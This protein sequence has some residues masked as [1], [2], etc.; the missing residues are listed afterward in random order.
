MSEDFDTIVI[1]AGAVG[2]SIARALSK[3]KKKVLLIEKNTIVGSGISSRNSEVIHA[4]IY[5]QKNS[6]KSK[7][8]VNG[9]KLLI[10]FCSE[11][12]IPFQLVGKL[13]VANNKYEVDSLLEIYKKGINNGVT[14][15]EI[16]DKSDIQSCEPELQAEKAI[17][18]PKT[19]I[20]D[21]HSFMISLLSDFEKNGGLI[22]LNSKVTSIKYSKKS[23]AISVNDN[24]FEVTAKNIINCAGLDAQKI[25]SL[26]SELDKR[27]IPKRY[28][29]KGNYFSYAEKVPFS[30]LIY[31]VPNKAGLGIHLTLDLSGRGKFGPDTEWIDKI[32]YSVNENLR[33]SFYEAIKKYFP[34]V[35]EES[36]MPD[37]S[38]IR[39][40]IVNE[41][42]P[43]SDFLIHTNKNHGINGY[44]ALYGI[45]SPGLTSALA[46]AD[47]IENITC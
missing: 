18:S 43:S 6:L 31:P 9:K 16:L 44:L 38:G 34:N 39:P 5:Y 27:N 25:S 40:K 14:D 30:K 17:L 35:N 7:F 23:F 10:D 24:D 4:G 2:L 15:L 8:C 36:L 13:I 41:Y 21:S 37:Y 19:G 47:Y 32:D 46:I 28:L 33:K 20:L 29:C 26:I 3:A 12:N 42:Q 11:N 1:G 22:S 45:E